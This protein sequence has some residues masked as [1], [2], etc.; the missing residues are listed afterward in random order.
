MN[1][2]R[3]EYELY[4]PMAEWLE[5]TLKD[6][7]KNQN[8]EIIVVDSHAVNLD[9]VL[10]KYDVVSEYPQVVG[11]QIQIDVLGIVKKRTC[12][13]IVFIEAKKT[14]LNLHDLGQLWAYCRLCNPIEAYL[15]SSSGIGS[16]EKILKNFKR[17][18]M[19]DFGDG[20]KIKKMKVAKW[21][22]GR[23]DIDYNTMV[24]II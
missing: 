5:T 6:K 21:D 20:K 8:C 19:L 3:Y 4:A 23:K 9:S 17:E 1:N 24:P 11:L 12:T 15:L 16:L 13:D 14:P 10:E 7:Y 2:V 18:D 22:I